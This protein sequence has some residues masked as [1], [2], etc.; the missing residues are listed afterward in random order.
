MGS[1]VN[2]N[3][4]KKENW[5]KFKS[6]T[7]AHVI[8]SRTKWMKTWESWVSWG[9]FSSLIFQGHFR[10]FWCNLPENVISKILSL[11]NY[12]VCCLSKLSTFSA[13]VISTHLLGGIAK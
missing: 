5:Q 8:A 6:Y 2:E 1:H 7:H 9:Y 10:V 3:G 13:P 4:K 11:Y 12:R